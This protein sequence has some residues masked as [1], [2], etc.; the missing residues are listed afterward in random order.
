MSAAEADHTFIPPTPEE[1]AP[2]FPGYQVNRLIA[3]GG[4]GAVY[5]AIQIS[6]DRAVAIKILPQEFTSDD[7]FRIAFETE[8]KAMARLNHP[9]LIGVYD[10]G[11]VNDMLFII[12]EY[13]PGI[14]LFHAADGQPILQE[15]VAPLLISICRGLAHAHENGII[16]RDI[17]PANILLNHDNEPK[18]GDFGLA[19]PL[20]RQ[21][22][23]GED[24]FGTPGYTAP[25][26]IRF[27]QSVDHRSDIFSIGVLLHELLTGMLPEADARP[28]SA[29][30]NCDP[31]FDAVIRKATH[32][33][34]SERYHDAHEIASE[35]ARIQ[36]T[37]R[38]R[39][40]QTSPPPG[41][42]PRIPRT[43]RPPARKSNHLKI[44]LIL[45]LLFA[46]GAVAYLYDQKS[47]PEQAESA[48]DTPVGDSSQ[49]TLPDQPVEPPPEPADHID[50]HAGDAASA[51]DEPR[52]IDGFVHW[53]RA[54]VQLEPGGP[55]S[56]FAIRSG[57]MG[58]PA[59]AGVMQAE[60]WEGNGLFTVTIES[61]AGVGDGAVAGLMVR[62]TIDAGSRYAFLGRTPSGETILMLRS[63]TDREAQIAARITA[64]H[65]RLRLHRHGDTVAAFASADGTTW[66]EV[67]LI[68][69]KSLATELMVGFAAAADGDEMSMTG[70]F[71]PCEAVE[72][73]G[74]HKVDGDPLPRLNMNELFRRAR[75]VMA[76]R[77]KP[78]I[79]EHQ[80]AT[81]ANHSSY[82]RMANQ[83][84]ARFDE[85]RSDLESTGHIPFTL[86]KQFNELDG[87]VGIHTTHLTRQRDIDRALAEKMAQLEA[88]YVN[89]LNS[90]L[91]R[92]DAENDTGAIQVLQEEKKRLLGSP[93]YF[94][95]LMAAQQ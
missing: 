49:S 15:E 10:F 92:S 90:Q 91:Q 2:L 93:Y 53:N 20:E 19:R 94:R 51:T 77:A 58:G 27:P 25:E 54:S 47:T 6:L 76:E 28:A 38:P 4:M 95:S 87:F 39:V 24:I 55:P 48:N 30:C 35:I 75:S 57:S 29:I 83:F 79:A 17:K 45:V 81:E 12:M 31:R 70:A 71:T 36:T 85:I 8:A 5:E 63:R 34:P 3:C 13:V 7:S 26:V 66:E 64:I 56:R 37:A 44:T 42:N 21:S 46:I 82:L 69:I 9:N 33:I 86:P 80:S 14:S 18:I 72:I 88:M 84:D 23:E 60:N 11:E 43:A 73:N 50:G 68:Q 78:L 62:E 67:G 61:L 59:D 52:V 89:G 65:N 32:P 22:Q 40:L 1:L 16:H 74:N 41:G